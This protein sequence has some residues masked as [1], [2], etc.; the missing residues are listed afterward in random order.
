VHN[1]GRERHA[2]GNE[3][4]AHRKSAAVFA[5]MLVLV[6]MLRTTMEAIVA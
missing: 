6:A 2:F 1:R 5:S 4:D 3:R